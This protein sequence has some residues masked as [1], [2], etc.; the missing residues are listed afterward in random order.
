MLPTEL[1]LRAPQGFTQG[2]CLSSSCWGSPW[3]SLHPCP[4]PQ[5]AGEVSTVRGHYLCSC[6]W[7]SGSRDHA[8]LRAQAP[9]ATKLEAASLPQEPWR[10]WDRR[11]SGAGLGT[12]AHPCKPGEVA[13]YSPRG[14]EPVSSHYRFISVHGS[15]ARKDPKYILPSPWRFPS[16]VV[17]GL[18]TAAGFPGKTCSCLREQWGPFQANIWQHLGEGSWD[19]LGKN[20]FGMM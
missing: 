6:P 18:T 12:H 15:P 19:Q 14:A 1:L 17:K 4:V 20:T 5:L 13:I 7:P 10:A 3:C 11:D 2:P 16:M 9:S 8:C